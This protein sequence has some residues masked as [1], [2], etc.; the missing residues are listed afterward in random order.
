MRKTEEEKKKIMKE[1][2]VDRL[3]SF[4]RL[5]TYSNSP[6]EYF[7]KY[8][9]NVEEDRTDCIYAYTG[10]LCH[11][12]LDRFYVNKISYNDMFFEF[13]DGWNI[14]R[15]ALQLK[16][17]RNDMD[18]DKKI[19]DKYYNDLALF[20]KNHTIIPYKTEIEPFV[21]LKI[22]N[23]ILI[24]YID[25]IYKDDDGIYNIIDFKSSSIYKGDNLR[26][27][28]GQLVIYAMALNQM[29]I[30]FNRIHCAFNFLK[31]VNVD[32]QQANGKT[33]TREIERS[34]IGNKLYN[35]VKMWAKK[36]GYT[37]E[38]PFMERFLETNDLGCLPL[39]VQNHFRISDCLVYIDLT[40]ELIQYWTEFV[41]NTIA[42]IR[43]KETQY[44]KTANENIFFDE[45]EQVEKQSYYYATLC[46]YSR[47][48]HKPYDQYLKKLENESTLISFKKNDDSDDNDDNFDWLNGI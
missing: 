33:T 35:S 43:D 18:K 6:Y 19:G 23:E 20:F 1:N 25:A 45:P 31:Y 13:E 47:K 28:S 10:S 22:F 5:S 12:I 8:V 3:W 42:E 38:E 34:E 9:L 30:P 7:L 15:E 36:E 4:S 40:D 27:H 48:L 14:N 41:K 11:D 44:K 46:S 2:N 37:G 21:S 24:G 39:S 29:G 17:D 26:F 32:C 16:F